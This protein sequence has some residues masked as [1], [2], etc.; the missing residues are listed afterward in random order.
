[1]DKGLARGT[2][3]EACDDPIVRRVGVLSTMLGEAVDVVAET[4]TLLLSAMA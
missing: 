3:L 2:I 4:L 1:M